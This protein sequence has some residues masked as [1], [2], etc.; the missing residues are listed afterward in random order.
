MKFDIGPQYTPDHPFM[1][2]ARLHQS[3]F[4][5]E[6][7]NVPF[8]THGSVLTK[9]D[10]EKLLNYYPDLGCREALRKR[11]PK[12]SK[13]RDSNL[14]R[15]EHIPF[16]LFAPLAQDLDVAKVVFTHAFGMSIQSVEDIQYEF[17]PKPVAA[18][19]NDGTAFD[20][21]VRYITEDGKKGAI[22]VE[23][24][25]T[26][27]AY[28]IGDSEKIQVENPQSL[29][30]HVTEKSG[31]FV[32][33]NRNQLATDDLRQVWRNHLLGLSMVQCGDIDEFYSITLYPSGNEHF[34]AVIPE[35]QSHLLPLAQEF[36]KGIQFED[37]FDAIPDGDLSA[38]KKWLKMRYLVNGRV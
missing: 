7:L 27:L 23:V 8:D 1:A 31:V 37:F 20:G 14:L 34:S 32:D 33:E 21:F 22:G 12:Y 16:N 5:A 29:Y 35:Y 11:Y 3:K 25:Y 13:Q 38:W 24:K 4:R 28:S 26:E 36:V 6:I 2:K 10:G 30:W 17:A 19:L 18:Y 9:E 15:S